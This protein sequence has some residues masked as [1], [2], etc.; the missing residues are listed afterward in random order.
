MSHQGSILSLGPRTAGRPNARYWGATP[1][2]SMCAIL[3]DRQ[4]EVG[5]STE[6]DLGRST[7]WK[8]RAQA[9]EVQA[10]LT[11][12]PLRDLWLLPGNYIRLYFKLKC[13]QS[14]SSRF[15]I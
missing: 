12:A 2:S 6:T 5:L 11:S 13:Y 9:E 14:S 7:P 3:S 8:E 1:T 4:P 10:V 15:F